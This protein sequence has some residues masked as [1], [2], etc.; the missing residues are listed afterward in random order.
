MLRLALACLLAASCA[1]QKSALKREA[2]PPKT[3]DLEK[4]DQWVARK[5]EEARITGASLA[6]MRGGKLVLVK[7]YGKSSRETGAP[8]TPETAFSIGSITKQFVC[9]AA[10]LLAEEGK[11]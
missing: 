4:I 6:V 9:A 5:L 2:E 8:V 3:F 7:G 10:L 1:A 11:L